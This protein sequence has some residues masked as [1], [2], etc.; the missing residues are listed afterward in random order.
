[1]RAELR[2]SQS[3]GEETDNLIR[4]WAEGRRRRGSSCRGGIKE[5]KGGDVR[6]EWA[7]SLAQEI[8]TLASNTLSGHSGPLAT[9]INRWSRWP[10][11]VL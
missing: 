8:S 10:R 6:K 7:S 4:E 2:L 11:F 1:M 9:Q 3:K 5:V